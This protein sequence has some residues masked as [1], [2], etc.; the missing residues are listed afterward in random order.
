MMPEIGK[1]YTCNKRYLFVYPEL[2]IAARCAEAA[3]SMMSIEPTAWKDLG[4]VLAEDEAKY[5]SQRLGCEIKHSRTS[6]IFLILDIQFLNNVIYANCLF[7][8]FPGWIAWDEWYKIEPVEN[9]K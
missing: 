3:V 8:T 1:L 5:W 9:Q 7:P 6:D 4:L 2:T